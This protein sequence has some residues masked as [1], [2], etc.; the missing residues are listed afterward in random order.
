[1]N[2]NLPSKRCPVCQRDFEWRRK[3]ARCWEE[4]RYC[5]DACRRGQGRPGFK[6]R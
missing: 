1:M 6:P 3:W 5:S 2:K 4:V